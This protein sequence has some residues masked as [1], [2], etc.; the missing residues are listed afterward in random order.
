MTSRE[1]VL[2]VFEGDLP[3]RCPIDFNCTPEA[4][5][6]LME[7][8]ALPDEETLR[9]HMGCDVRVVEP[10]MKVPNL[11]EYYRHY[12]VRMLDDRRYLDNW[13]IVWQR[14]EM[15]SGDVFYEVVGSPLEGVR[16]AMEVEDYP[17]PDPADEWDFSGIRHQISRYPGLAIAG[18]T[19][20]VFDD[21]W[22]LLGFEKMLADIALNPDIVRAVLRKTCDY[23]LKFA[24]LLLEAGGGMIDIMW[25]YDD[26][27]TQKGLIMSPDACREFV[28]PLVRERTELF[29]GYGARAV[30]HSCG[31]IVPI[32]EDLI[33]AG[34]DALNPI[35]I[36][37]TGMDRKF[38]KE[39]FADRLVFHGGIDQQ[40]VLVSGGPDEVE[41]ETRDCIRTLGWDGGYIISTTHE[42]EAD[43]PVENLEV[44]FRIAKEEAAY[45]RSPTEGQRQG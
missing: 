22:R 25:T 20:A 32:I 34:V 13:G 14:A 40:R 1:R 10:S 8:F 33:G 12:F 36:T 7:R 30:M 11:G 3:D 2:A 43:I 41:R 37:A 15:I 45:R 16:S 9:R 26:L 38:L 18:R 31:S 42:I 6:L 23:W 21:A 5:R 39:R 4:E 28:M 29:H 24:R 19:A 17:F 44:L 27:G 35:Q